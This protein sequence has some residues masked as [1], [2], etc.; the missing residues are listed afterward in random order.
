MSLPDGSSAI[1]HTE[2]FDDTMWSS[3]TSPN[4]FGGDDGVFDFV[5]GK[6]SDDDGDATFEVPTFIPIS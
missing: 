2:A 5:V 1:I 3:D 4:K 6:C